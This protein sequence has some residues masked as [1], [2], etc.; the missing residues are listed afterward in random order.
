MITQDEYILHKNEL[1][2][3]LSLSYTQKVHFNWNINNYIINV[4][5]TSYIQKLFERL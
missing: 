5:T 1:I 2:V 4:L 3:I